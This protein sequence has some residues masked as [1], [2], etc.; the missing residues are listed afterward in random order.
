MATKKKVDEFETEIAPDEP[1]Q[2]EKDTGDNG[3]EVDDK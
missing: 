3:G 1:A 2:F